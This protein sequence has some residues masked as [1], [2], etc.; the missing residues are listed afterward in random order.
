MLNIEDFIRRIQILMDYYNISASVFADKL[1]VQRSSLSHL[2][3]GRNKPSL[4]FIMRITEAYPEA[5]LYWL[6]YGQGEFPKNSSQS[7]SQFTGNPQESFKSQSQFTAATA[8][9]V[10]ENELDLFSREESVQPEFSEAQQLQTETTTENLEI[11]RIVIFYTNGT[12]KNYN[13]GQ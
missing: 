9:T 10:A 2:M 13:P 7:Q 6:L 4:D 5:D 12:F 8:N 3:S 1:T 11:E